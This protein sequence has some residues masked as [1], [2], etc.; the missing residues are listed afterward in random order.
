M[1]IFAIVNVAMSQPL[2]GTAPAVAGAQSA[3]VPGPGS[4]TTT[5]SQMT[6]A[7]VIELVGL[8]LSDE[9]VIDKIYA[10]PTA[11]DTSMTGLRAL[12]AAK[13]SDAVIRVM[14]N[15][16]SMQG[17]PNG[18]PAGSSDPPPPPPLAPMP[19]VASEAPAPNPATVLFHSTDGKSRLYVT[20]H[21]INEVVSMAHPSG[22]ASTVAQTGDDPR[23]VEIQADVLKLCPSFVIVSNNPE[24]SDYVLVFRRQTGKRSSFYAMGGLTGLAIA[25]GA[26]VDGAS[27]FQLNGDMVYA[28]KE[29]TVEK[30]IRDTCAHIPPPAVP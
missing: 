1:F 24:H 17:P 22:A 28:T 5:T 18:P 30:A 2:V 6:N 16:Q 14:I 26:K 4:V 12:K 13:V 21:P 23:T 11:F 25:A 20:D 9:V 19:P 8:G 29:N 7:D 27:L 10:S 15:P 3:T